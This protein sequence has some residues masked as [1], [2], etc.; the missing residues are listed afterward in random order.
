MK[1]LLKVLAIVTLTTSSI[2]ANTTD[3][4]ASANSNKTKTFAIG[5]Y[6]GAGTLDMHLMLDKL[7][8][9]TVSIVIKDKDGRIIN[10]EN[11]TKNTRT[12][13][14]KYDFSSAEDGLYTIEITDGNE[15]L[16]RTV[17]LD[18]SSEASYRK[19]IVE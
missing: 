5:L 19:M 9:K 17:N 3:N 2:W 7:T 16:K 10:R 18:S 4:D 1:S 15:T 14:G 12:Y 8:G 6:R 11:I 13:H